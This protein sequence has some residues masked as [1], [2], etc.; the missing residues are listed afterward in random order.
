MGAQ[1]VA[2]QIAQ[3]IFDGMDHQAID[4]NAAGNG[5]VA[6]E[7]RVIAVMNLMTWIG[8]LL[9]SVYYITALAIT[10]FKMDPSWILLSCGVIMLLTGLLSKLKTIDKLQEQRQTVET[11]SR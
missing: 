6:G 10:G 9:A 5:Q 11:G 3:I 1:L 8:I 7:G 4:R 2:R